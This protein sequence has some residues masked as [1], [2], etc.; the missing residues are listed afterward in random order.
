MK[1]GYLSL[2]KLQWTNEKRLAF[3]GHSFIRNKLIF[4]VL[5][6]KKVI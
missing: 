5:K 4:N 1:T 2:A 6:N 3:D